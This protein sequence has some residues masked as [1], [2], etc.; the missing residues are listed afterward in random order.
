M[1]MG[2]V[3]LAWFMIQLDRQWEI[4]PPVKIALVYGGGP[5]GARAVLSLVA[6]SMITVAG[7]VFSI[8]IVALTLA[9]QQFGPRL[10][11]NFMKDRGN[12]IVLGTFIGTFLYCILILPNIVGQEGTKFVPYFSVNMGML[13][14]V[15]SLIV[16][17]YFIHHIPALMQVSTVINEVTQQLLQTIRTFF[18]DEFNEGATSNKPALSQGEELRKKIQSKGI[19]IAANQSGYIQAIDYEGL[20]QHSIEHDLAI[21]IQ[22]RPGHF[23]IKNSSV[24]QILSDE[25]RPDLNNKIVNSA[26]FLGEKRTPTQDIEYAISE[27]VEIALRALSPGINDPRTAINCIDRLSEGIAE[28]ASRK[29]SLP[30]FYD[31]DD[32][33]RVM[34]QPQTFRSAIDQSFNEIRQI[35]RGNTAICIRL[36]EVLKEIL[37]HTYRDTDRQ[38]MHIHAD[39]ILRSCR[40]SIKEECDLEQ[41]ESRYQDFLQTLES[42]G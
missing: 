37:P 2:A 3:F 36:L 14:A 6:S 21:L 24:A 7:V 27:L 32:K 5:E 9:S 23:L 39:M 13:L 12:Q 16:L 26:L 41:A 20:L 17:I 31:S 40:D 38:A 8:T 33:L 28:L 1:A 18:P 10:L 4:D 42:L 19:N 35:G 22:F 25:D 34:G 11:R 30:Y 29:I 15:N